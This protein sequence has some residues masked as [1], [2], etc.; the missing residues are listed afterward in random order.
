M[1]I[2]VK[3]DSN[4]AFRSSRRQTLFGWTKT[5][6]GSKQNCWC[7]RLARRWCARAVSATGE[8]SDFFLVGRFRREIEE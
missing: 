2:F 6:V 8:R 1:R 3:F 7:E 4:P 5:V